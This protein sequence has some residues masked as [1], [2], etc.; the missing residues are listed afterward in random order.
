MR[1]SLRWLVPVSVV[2]AVAGGTAINAVAAGNA[3]QLPART[4]HELIEAVAAA[5][6]TALSGSVGSRVDLG[7]PVLQTFVGQLAGSSTDPQGLAARLLTGKNTIKVWADGPTR[8]KVSLADTSGDL[9]AVHNGDQAWAYSAKEKTAWH[10][11]VPAD[12]GHAPASITP[13]VSPTDVDDLNPAQL[14]DR[15]LTGLGPSTDITVGD[16]ETVADRAAYPLTLTPKTSGTLVDHI[17]IAVDGEKSVPLRVQVFAK[18]KNEPAIEVGF[19]TITFATPDASEFSFTP[20]AGVTVQEL[21]ALDRHGKDAVLS[22]GSP[23][24]SPSASPAVSPSAS[25]AVSPSASPAVS[26]SASPAVSPAGPADHPRPIVTGSDWATIVELPAGSV[27][28]MLGSG[29][30]SGGPFAGKASPGPGN[31]AEVSPSASST[32]TDQLQGL[33]DQFTTAV[34]GGR[35]I[36]AS[37]FSVLF[38]DDGRVFVGSVPVQSLVDAAKK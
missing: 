12:A 20:P 13:S 37:L 14:A 17:E 4:P 23:A 35:A 33:F 15:L 9:T 22:P 34:D 11:T 31:S 24:T 6:V 21:G 36:K 7:L 18:G 19:T 28:A 5:R 26:P 2:A 8:Q 1:T 16:S 25:P 10:G 27:P 32:G 3:P 30:R 29:A 38:T